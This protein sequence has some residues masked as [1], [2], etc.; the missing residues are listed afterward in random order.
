MEATI[1][2]KNK[3]NKKTYT[4]KTKTPVKKQKTT[5]QKRRDIGEFI[6]GE[7]DT[8][9]PSI[10]E[11]N[12]KDEFRPRIIE[13][14]LSKKSCSMFVEIVDTF[15]EECEKT[16]NNDYQIVWTPTQLKDFDDKTYKIASARF[17]NFDKVIIRK[18]VAETNGGKYIPW[19]KDH[20]ALKTMQV[21]LN[22]HS[23]YE[24]G[25]TAYILA[26]KFVAIPKRITGNAIVHGDE[27][28]HGVTK[29]KNGKRYS[30][31]FLLSKS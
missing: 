31:F 6:N 4:K 15:S 28:M 20:S 21:I 16:E 10:G 27:V 24:G 25:D 23:E 14:L 7:L 22:D 13:K 8:S 19:H 2:K 9:C 11:Y 5:N 12:F 3:K 26:N 29:L 18:V 17:P 30:L 1:E